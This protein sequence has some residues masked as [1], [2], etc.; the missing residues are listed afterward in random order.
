MKVQS[1]TE[2][3]VKLVEQVSEMRDAN[4]RLAEKVDALTRDLHDALR[5]LNTSHPPEPSHDN[6]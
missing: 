6:G 4:A 5:F 1:L 2:T 3:N